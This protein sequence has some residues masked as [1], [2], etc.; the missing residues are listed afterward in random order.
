MG[1]GM[2]TNEERALPSLSDLRDTLDEFFGDDAL[3]DENRH[4]ERMTLVCAVVC[5]AF[6]RRGMRATVVG[7][8][9]VEFHAPGAYTTFDTD[10][11]VEPA[12]TRPDRSA[13]DGVFGALGFIKG[14]ARHWVRDDFLIEVPSSHLE[15]P[16]EEH[17]V[18]PHTF[19]VVKKEVVLVERLVEFYQTGHTGY[20]AQAIAM[21]RAFGAELEPELLERLLHE[22]EVRVVYELMKQLASSDVE[23]TDDLLRAERQELLESS[24]IS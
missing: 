1:T 15:G 20:G 24:S 23:I 10:L 22:Q 17:Q 6:K 5:D 12:T 2:G 4:T 11:V 3:R 21:I 9:A 13:L 16:A 7:G 14:P 19:R 8:G 18:G